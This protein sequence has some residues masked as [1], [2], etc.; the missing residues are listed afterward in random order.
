MIRYSGLYCKFFLKC[1]H[2]LRAFLLNYGDTTTIM[3]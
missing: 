3:R 1:V 2:V